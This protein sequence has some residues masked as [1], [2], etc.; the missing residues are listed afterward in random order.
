[1][2]MEV[3]M[4]DYYKKWRA[5]FLPSFEDSL[6]MFSRDRSNEPTKTKYPILWKLKKLEDMTKEELCEALVDRDKQCRLLQELLNQSTL[7]VG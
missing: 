7:L 2:L 1:M 6:K 4:I 5:H 3:S